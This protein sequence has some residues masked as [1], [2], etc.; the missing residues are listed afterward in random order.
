[1][2]SS[3]FEKICIQDDVLNTTDKIRYAVFK[4]AQ[5]ITPAQYDAISA[6]TSS[7]TF[8]I[9]LPSE[10]TVFSRRIMV[11]AQMTIR[12]VGTLKAGLAGANNYLINY[13]YS[14]ALGPFPFQ[15]LCNTVQATINNNTVSQNTRDVMYQLLRF[16]DRR[17]LARF[18]NTAPTMYDSYLNY[19]DA[20][21]ANNNPLGAWNNT[22]N[23]QD[24]QG[25][26]SFKIDSIAGNTAGSA[27]DEKTVDITFTVR[28]PLMLSPF[29]WCDPKSNN[30]GMY[31]VQTLNFV[32]NF[33]AANKIIRFA[34]GQNFNNDTATV[35][36]QGFG[37]LPSLNGKP[38]LL[39]EFYTRQPSNLVSARNC[40]PFAEYPRYYSNV[41]SLTQGN[42]NVN[43][44]SIQLNSV[45]DKLII[46]VR[47]RLGSQDNFDTD[48]FLPITG[49]N[50]SFN[51]AAGL[52]SSATS[53][54]LW[55]YSVECGSNQTW[56]EWSGEAN[57]GTQTPYTT[58]PAGAGI[59]TIKTCGSVLCLEMGKH[60]ELS[61]TYAPG[62]IGSF[63]LMIKLT[64]NNN[65][66]ANIASDVYEIVLITM[67][68]GV[69]TIER[70]TSQTYTAIL[71]R[72]DVLAVSSSPAMS[73]S[74]L[75]RLVGGSWEDSIKSLCSAVA[76]L[77]G[78]AEQLKDFIVGKGSSGGGYSGGGS[79]G[80]K[81]S[82]HLAM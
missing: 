42:H 6:T 50:I 51:N 73:K 2:S 28:E 44:Q 48:S 80:G 41:P 65:T 35:S 10:S 18:N 72:A 9:Q 55:K 69:F 1:M 82:K 79:S 11:E 66:G 21:G 75:A 14:S 3:D 32:F 16:N 61:D 26:G 78:K 47:K 70:G 64:V 7:A 19:A 25:R 40:L 81:I 38:R 49:V 15:S 30:Q 22:S 74:S 57:V 68:S 27:G 8:N 5:N 17:E 54:D 76:P 67:N 43:L 77:A 39:M 63:Q 31:G 52:L 62:S 37:S 53:F 24:F 60:V 46:A 56:V 58:D 20:L 36:F 23:D 29:I 13:G 4:G 45:P 33:G 71:S 34:K 59:H 12:V